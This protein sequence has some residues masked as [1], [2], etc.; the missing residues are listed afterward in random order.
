VAG[1]KLFAP[2]KEPLHSGQ[3]SSGSQQ[4]KQRSKRGASVLNAVLAKTAIARHVT[5]WA[6]WGRYQIVVVVVHRLALHHLD[7]V[8]AILCAANLIEAPSGYRR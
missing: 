3:M 1:A 2:L 7:S 6:H 8:G 5:A 4:R